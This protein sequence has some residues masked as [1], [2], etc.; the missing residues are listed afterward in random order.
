MD[1][2]RCLKS[3]TITIF[4]IVHFG[5]EWSV[6]RSDGKA[7]Y[8]PKTWTFGGIPTRS[9]TLRGC[10]HFERLALFHLPSFSS[11]ACQRQ[12]WPSRRFCGGPQVDSCS[13]GVGEISPLSNA[14]MMKTEENAR[15][16]NTKQI[17][18]QMDVRTAKKTRV[19]KSSLEE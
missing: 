16:R 17:W 9:A 8:W 5:I 1:R 4:R 12:L 6:T 11:M 15:D 14:P 10:W 13:M 19:K 3:N 7:K 18:L 2:A